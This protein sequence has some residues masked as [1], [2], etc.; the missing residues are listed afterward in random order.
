MRTLSPQRL[1][2]KATQISSEFCPE[3]GTEQKLPLHQNRFVV[4]Q[5]LPTSHVILPKHTHTTHR[6]TDH[7][8][9]RGAEK[10]GVLKFLDN[11][12]IL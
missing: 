7:P 1:T 12:W 3:V 4:C 6:Y 2:R 11:Q 5:S 9:T 8:L 10:T